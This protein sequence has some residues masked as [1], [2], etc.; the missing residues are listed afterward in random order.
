MPECSVASRA[1]SCL[2]VT[3]GKP[4]A[5][6]EPLQ[7]RLA[8]SAPD[9]EDERLS[10]WLVDVRA[11]PHRSNVLASLLLVTPMGPSLDRA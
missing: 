6:N 7:Q 3:V 11:R 2:P 8:N 5:V 9:V 1:E 10:T 4:G